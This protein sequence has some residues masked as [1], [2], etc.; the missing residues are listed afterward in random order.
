VLLGA[1]S[2]LG[3][4]L[5]ARAATAQSDPARDRP[6]EGDLLVRADSAAPTPLTPDNLALG[7]GQVMAWP[8]ESVGNVVRDGSRLNNVLLWYGRD[9]RAYRHASGVGRF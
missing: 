1:G 3:V 5:M 4:G 7:A 8:I 9:G 6:Q 2:G